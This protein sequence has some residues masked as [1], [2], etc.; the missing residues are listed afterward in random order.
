MD[1]AGQAIEA[2]YREEYALVIAALVGAFGDI[3]LAEDA[4]QDAIA[5][6]LAR[7][8]REGV[9]RRPA[10]WLT[11]VAR[12]RGIDALRRRAT[13]LNKQADLAVL[14]ELE[15]QEEP[16]EEADVVPDVRLQLMFT[17]CHPSLSRPAQVALTLKTL[18]GL[19]TPQ[20]ARAFLVPEATLAQRLVRA[21]RKIR[22]AGIPFRVP[23][24]ELLHERLGAVL[25]VIYLIFNE[26]YA[27]DASADVQRRALADEAIRLGRVLA[28]LMPEEAEVL[29]LL[30][31][32]LLHNARRAARVDQD[33]VLVTLEE[34]DRSRW[35]G[36]LI[37]EGQEFAERAAGA[38]R[39]GP[40]QLQA[41]IAAVHVGRVAAEATDW[42]A[43]VALY[44]RLMDLQPTPVVALNRAAAIAMVAGPEA[45]LRLIE[46]PKLHDAL[47]GYQPYHAARADLL[48]RA[49]RPGEAAASYRR[50]LILTESAAER[51]F[52]ERRLA[53]IKG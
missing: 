14:A 39:S 3:G 40:Y 47:G 11:T 32:M 43:I 24:A 13:R 52:L 35:D 29:G 21:K 2:V 18:G 37:T 45:G 15:R 1:T 46:A 7:W 31:L 38:G 25:L 53:Q 34:Q 36:E 10:A 33:G 17:C 30:A 50:A 4:L 22:D 6:A 20:I 9:P 51:A 19:S 16:E 23:P 42:R 28:S 44:G 26:G 27:P 41:A 12:R 49:G 5:A 48:R 8:P